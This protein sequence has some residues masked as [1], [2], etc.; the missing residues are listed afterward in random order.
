M[1]IKKLTITSLLIGIIVYVFIGFGVGLPELI[2]AVNKIKYSYL[3][4]AILAYAFNLFL[5]TLRW[6]K[7][8]DEAKIK[9]GLWK[10]YLMT[11]AGLTFSNITPSSRM[12]GEPVRAYFLNQH[13]KTKMKD[14]F[15]TIVSAR[16]FDA[17]IFT[18]ISIIIFSYSIFKLQLPSFINL[19]LL[20]SLIIAIVII[21]FIVYISVKPK[22]AEK[23]SL[24]LIKKFKRFSKT[25][26]QKN[27]ENKIKKEIKEYSENMDKFLKTKKL[28][29]NCSI[30]TILMWVFDVLRMYL[31]FLGLG[32]EVNP[33]MLLIVLVLS[34]LA[35]GI[36]LF[37][38][39][40]AIT[41]S[42]MI[43]VY[44][45]F[46]IPLAI[47]GVATVL[48][49]LIYFWLYTFIGL[50]ASYKLGIKKYE[51]YE[52]KERQSD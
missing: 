48:D 42:T 47:A 37:P 3:L 9:I 18:L 41:E 50:I 35:G 2:K 40:I 22:A 15:A 27:F 29:I 17:I 23:L 49:R 12:G 13:S 7:I 10:L 32:L 36:P 8:T 33:A 39:G 31:I 14:S 1:N 26:Q 52:E 4:L 19:L 11:L 34:G 20:I 45:S 38:G 43:L 28:W 44:S 51:E 6:K 25:M 21:W 16:I 30:Y 46:S 5:A 24:W